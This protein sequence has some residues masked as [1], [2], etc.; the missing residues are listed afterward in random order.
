MSVL[1]YNSASTFLTAHLS[2]VYFFII[3]YYKISSYHLCFDTIGSPVFIYTVDIL[4]I[5]EGFVEMGRESQIVL[6]Q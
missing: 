4:Y 2:A 6:L 3:M 5:F 1:K